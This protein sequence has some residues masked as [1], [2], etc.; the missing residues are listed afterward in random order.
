MKKIYSIHIKLISALH[1]NAGVGLDGIRKVVKRDGRPYIPATVV[2]GMIR[3]NFERINRTVDNEYECLGKEN[4][5]DDCNC[6]SCTLFGKAGFQKSRVI[7]D[8]L[9]TNQA[10]T[11]ELRA[12]VAINRQL[13]TNND[14]SLVFQ[15]VVSPRDEKGKEIIFTGEMVVYY[16]PEKELAYEPHLLTAVRLIEG[17][18]SGKSRGLGFVEVEVTEKHA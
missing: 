3:D 2:K 7:L 4:V 12:N 13:R 8:N 5:K 11:T 1:I 9:E 16:P 6:I 15:E 17:I 10:T 14:G 18:G